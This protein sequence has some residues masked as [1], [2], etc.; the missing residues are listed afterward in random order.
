MRACKRS[1]FLRVASYF[2]CDCSQVCATCGFVA[3]HSPL[4]M[5][6]VWVCVSVSVC[7]CVYK[8][9]ARNES[10][11]CH[12]QQSTRHTHT[13]TS[14][15][16]CLVRTLYGSIIC[17]FVFPHKHTYT[18][19]LGSSSGAH[20]QANN[21]LFATFICYIFIMHHMYYIEACIFGIT[22]ACRASLVWRCA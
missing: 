4:C 21:G 7:V 19:P 9:Y 11:C 10:V 6:Y 20:T 8:D 16:R 17:R 3:Q 15:I 2:F 1:G 5:Y 22:G 12:L 13:L 18:H 14:M